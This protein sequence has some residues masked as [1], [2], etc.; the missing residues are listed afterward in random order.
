[1][2]SSGQLAPEDM[3]ARPSNG[4]LGLRLAWARPVTALSPGCLATRS[5]RCLRACVAAAS[6]HGQ[7]GLRERK[8]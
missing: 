1:M 4:Q 8:R 2:A 5:G 7:V 3:V 6:G